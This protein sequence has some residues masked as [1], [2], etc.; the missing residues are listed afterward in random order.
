MDAQVC[1]AP[2]ETYLTV[3][4]KRAAGSGPSGVG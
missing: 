2:T 4:K 3:S 1:A